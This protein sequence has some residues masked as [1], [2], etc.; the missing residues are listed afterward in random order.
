MLLL[1]KNGRVSCPEVG[2]TSGQY[3]AILA[4]PRQCYSEPKKQFTFWPTPLGIARLQE[5]EMDVPADLAWIGKRWRDFTASTPAVEARDFS[6][7]LATTPWK[8]QPGAI[9]FGTR[10]PSPY[11]NMGMGTGKSLV[12]VGTIGTNR[13]KKTLILCP[14]AVVGVW[15]REFR[16]HAHEG[17]YDVLPLDDRYA[18][19]GKKVEAAKL[20]LA[21]HDKVVVAINYES[22][23]RD[24]F[25]KWAE[26]QKWD[27]VVCDEI[28]RIK[29]PSGPT[30]SFASN[31]DCGQ[32]IG[33]SGTMLPHSPLDAYGQFR[34][35]EPALLG[36][37]FLQFKKRYAI[38]GQYGEVKR[39]VNLEDLHAIIKPLV[40]RV[41]TDVLDLPPATNQQFRF[42]LSSKVMSVYKKFQKE[43]FSRINEGIITADN[44]LVRDLRLQQ[45]TSGFY[46]DDVTKEKVSL[47]EQPK[48]NAMLDWLDAIP[49]KEKFVIFTRF[50]WDVETVVAALLKANPRLRIGRLTGDR[51]D[52]TRDA[53]F[54]TSFDCYV[55]NIASGGVGVDLT[56]ANHALYYS[57]SWNGGDYEQSLRRLLRPGQLLSCHFAHLIATDTVDEDIYE[58]Y[59]K[60]KDLASIVIDG[61]KRRGGA[62]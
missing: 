22:A 52:L 23:R 49:A 12:T 34:F 31:L 3:A 5:A 44:V 7:V 21:R 54:D 18:N 15:P 24:P 13:H 8:H 39:F 10:C 6:E 36:S 42:N 29:S 14:N 58:G 40:Y 25:A 1:Q 48:I 20:A 50:K 43:L 51:N 61:V 2:L 30:T 38:E 11:F 19:T 62:R 28:H 16:K 57:V 27:C 26:E 32:P 37:N 60:K 53:T 56:A 35:L 45:I 47:D 55:V 59:E 46:V 33:L 4:Q 41:D 9:D 17:E